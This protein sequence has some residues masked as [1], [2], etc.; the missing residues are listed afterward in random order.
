MKEIIVSNPATNYFISRFRD[1]RTGTYECN[2][3][4]ETISFFLA[5]ELSSLLETESVEI[6][7]PLGGKSCPVLQEEVILVPV[8][9]AG[10]AMLSGFQ[11][12]LPRFQTGFIWAHRNK[13]AVAELDKAKFPASAEGKTFILLDTMLATASTLNLAVDIVKQYKPKQI[14]CASILATPVGL[15]NL[16]RDVEAVAVADVSDSLDGNMYV[17]PGVGDSGDRLYG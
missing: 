13:E 9:R 16:S 17:Y 5:G 11:R 3:C 8:L 15:K 4:V 14:L 2:F 7:T 1:K 6:E 12:I 10:I